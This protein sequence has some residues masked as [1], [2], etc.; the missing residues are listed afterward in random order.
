MSKWKKTK[1]SLY[2]KSAVILL[3]DTDVLEKEATPKLEVEKEARHSLEVEKQ[4]WEAKQNLEVEKEAVP[5][6]EVEREAR[7]G[8]EGEKEKWEVDQNL[9]VEKDA[10]S[11]NLEAGSDPQVCKSLPRII[12]CEDKSAGEKRLKKVW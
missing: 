2:L 4:K 7:L 6:L 12:G 3:Q 8:L 11:P 10:T 9:E 1:K 5:K